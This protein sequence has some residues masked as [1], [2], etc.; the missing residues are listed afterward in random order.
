MTV[1]PGF[2]AF[3][4]VL[5]TSREDDAVSILWDLGTAG[6]ET[7]PAGPDAVE[8]IAFFDTRRDLL[9]SLRQAL[10]PLDPASIEPAVVPE[11]DWVE[12]FRAGFEAFSV[13]RF[14]VQPAWAVTPPAP[15]Q[16]PIIVDP[17]RAF[18]TGTHESTRLC[19]GCLEALARRAPL[20]APVLDLG[21]GS[22]IL[23]IAARRLGATRVVAADNDPDAV[24]S[25][26]EH[27]SL[28]DTPLRIVLADGGRGLRPRR[29]GLVL[30]NIAAPF[31]CARAEEIAALVAPG[32]VLVLSGFLGEDL[33][34]VRTAYT[35]LGT[36]ESLA[37]GEW[38]ALLVRRPA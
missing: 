31:L 6:V 3:R 13:G 5:P 36:A 37:L 2:H 32:G 1:G 22:G 16:L 14:L 27:S 11:V 23:A 8:L 30:A 10:A 35:A 12:R 28:N 34:T 29:F 24:R 26:R 17:G 33:D 18:G 4:I 15:G 25:A 20:P 9:P 7:R 21:T 38:A 19:L